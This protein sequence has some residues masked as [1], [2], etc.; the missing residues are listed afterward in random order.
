MKIFYLDIYKNELNSNIL[1]NWGFNDTQTILYMTIKDD[2]YYND[3]RT[4]QGSDLE[5]FLNRLL[6]FSARKKLTLV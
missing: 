1:S 3:K 6:N 5:K 4:L 2:I